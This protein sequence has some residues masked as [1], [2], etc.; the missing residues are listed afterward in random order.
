MR[1]SRRHS[2]SR[3]LNRAG[4]AA[5]LTASLFGAACARSSDAGADSGGA[6]SGVSHGPLGRPATVSGTDTA[7]LSTPRGPAF[8]SGDSAPGAKDVSAEPLQWTG[9]AV[10]QRLTQAGLAPVQRGTL[11]QADLGMNGLRLSV[12]NGAAEVQAFIFGDADA[13]GNAMRHLDPARLASGGRTASVVTD[14]NLGAI[15]LTSDEKVRQRIASALVA[16]RGNG[17]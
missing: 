1:P 6:T 13:V 2:F 17:R 11:R 15:V 3:S 9:D 16:R 12:A 4:S 10:V 14:N 5:L 7:T 8:V